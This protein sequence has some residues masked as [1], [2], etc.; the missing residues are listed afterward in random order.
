MCLFLVVLVAFQLMLLLHGENHFLSQHMLFIVV[1]KD[2]VH[3]V[4]M[5]VLSK[6]LRCIID[7]IT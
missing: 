4:P 7:S 3:E 2:R 6:Q 1:T 5:P